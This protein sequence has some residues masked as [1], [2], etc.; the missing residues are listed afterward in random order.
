MGYWKAEGLDVANVM[1]AGGPAAAKALSAGDS[2]IMYGGWGA[3]AG[4]ASA[5]VPLRI[6][7]TLGQYTPYN[8]V[9]QP[10]IHSIQ[11]LSGA[12]WAVESVGGVSWEYA[13]IWLEA[14]HLGKG[15][16]NFVVAGSPADRGRALI[17]G[18]VDASLLYDDQLNE[19]LKEKPDLRILRN[20]VQMAQ[21]AGAPSQVVFAT[22]DDVLKNKPEMIDAFL[23]GWLKANRDVR[24]N[25]DLFLKMADLD[26]SGPKLPR[27]QLEKL[28]QGYKD[29]D[30]FPVNGGI[31]RDLMNT[32]AT[33]YYNLVNPEAKKLNFDQLVDYRPLARVLKDLGT[34]KGT[35]DVPDYPI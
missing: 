28:W 17:A 18:K 35:W 34:V 26:F 30:Y 14:V 6:I 31:R 25:K 24:D 12:S 8:L 13:L 27:S 2:D 29:N 4:A 5:G 1:V 9:V 22:R 7:A 16:V 20:Y 32:Y 33:K 15:A 23:R 11:D 19:T 21:E 10:R 3:A